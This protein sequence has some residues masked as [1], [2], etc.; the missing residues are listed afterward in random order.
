[1]IDIS[2]IARF[3]EER[4]VRE[5]Q[6]AVER[7]LAE[8]E[9]LLGE[10][11]TDEMRASIEETTLLRHRWSWYTVDPNDL[12]PAAL[13]H[14]HTAL[15]FDKPDGAL[16]QEWDAGQMLPPDIWARAARESRE[17]FDD[18]GLAARAAAL[19]IA[20]RWFTELLHKANGQ[21]IGL[22]IEKDERWRL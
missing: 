14:V 5:Q 16:A 18:E 6:A 3:D 13:A 7:A 8:A 9:L 21:P 12:Y 4:T 11:L 17:D 2:K 1:M 10:Y 20:R 22:H 19:E 15:G